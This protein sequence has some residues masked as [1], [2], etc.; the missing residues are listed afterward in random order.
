MVQLVAVDMDGTFLTTDKTYDRGRFEKILA[1]LKQRQIKFVVASGNQYAQLTSFFPE[2][3]E[4]TFVAENG[5]LIYDQ[6]ELIRESHFEKETLI[7][8]IHFLRE[9]YPEVNMVLNSIQSAYMERHLPAEF[10]QFVAF[11]CHALEKYV[12]FALGVP[13]AQTEEIA[14]AISAAFPDKAQAVS[15]GHGSVDIILPHYHKANG[16]KFLAD[17]WQIDPQDMMAFGDGHNDL[18]MLAYV[19]HSYAMANG[20]PAVLQTAKFIAPSNN[21]SGVLQVLEDFLSQ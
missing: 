12:K 1:E 5:V 4:L 15:S 9:N 7:S 3:Q 11:Y 13:T 2:S 14:R 16:L 6:N 8:M 10:Q 18:E 17:Y 19:G 20:A 21:E